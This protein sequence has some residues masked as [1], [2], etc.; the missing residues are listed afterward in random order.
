M[1]IKDSSKETTHF[2]NS[3]FEGEFGK[4]ISNLI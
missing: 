1:E 4:C 2:P 3:A